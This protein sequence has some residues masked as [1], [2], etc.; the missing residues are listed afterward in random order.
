MKTERMIDRES[1][2]KLYVQIY[3]IIREKVESGEWPEGTQIPTEDDLCRTYDVSKVT[4]REA[5]QE[6][7]RE[8]YLRRQQGKGTF[9]LPPMPQIGLSMRAGLTEVPYGEEVTV[10]KEIIE[11]RILMPEEEIRLLLQTE[12]KIRYVLLRKYIDGQPCILEELFIPVIILAFDE[13]DILFKSIVDVIEEKGTKKIWKVIQTCEVEKIKG[14]AA[15]HLLMREGSNVLAV[16][17]IYFSPDRSPLAY[18]HSIIGGKNK[19]RI[20]YERIK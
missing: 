10:S 7:V 5:I 12:E 9:V 14:E 18:S 19:V 1:K 4:V 6:L 20:E 16:K 11:S 17:R 3:S 13:E 8:G 2:Q 15:S